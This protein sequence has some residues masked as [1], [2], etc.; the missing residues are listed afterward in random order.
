MDKSKP[1]QVRKKKNPKQSLKVHKAE[2]ETGNYSSGKK[3]WLHVIRCLKSL[4]QIAVAAEKASE[5]LGT[6]MKVLIAR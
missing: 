4:T 3:S 6:I 1:M 5:M 2:R